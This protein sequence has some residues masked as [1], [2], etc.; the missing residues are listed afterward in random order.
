MTNR[1]DKLL[2]CMLGLAIVTGIIVFF[3][4]KSYEDDEYRIY[5]QKKAEIEK[6][7][8]E[9]EKNHKDWDKRNEMKRF[10][11][12]IKMR[13]YISIHENLA[14]QFKDYE[15][16]TGLDD[17][18]SLFSF[19]RNL[20][21]RDYYD[22]DIRY[23]GTLMRQYNNIPYSPIDIGEIIQERNRRFRHFGTSFD[24]YRENLPNN[25]PLMRKYHPEPFGVAGFIIFMASYALIR[26]IIYLISY[27]R[28]VK[29][30]ARNNI[31]RD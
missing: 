31:N 24:D 9:W 20:L 30:A 25:Y 16:R 17:P 6:E 27:N 8:N 22:D 1:E 26:G 18:T 19:I 12:E 3:I 11:I 28:A 29:R 7:L 23:L 15:L 10:E 13:H 2:I 4:A 21:R 14:T 5:L